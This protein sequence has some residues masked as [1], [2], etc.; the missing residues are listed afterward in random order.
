MK[1]AI[2][3]SLGQLLQKWGKNLANRAVTSKD[4]AQP[5]DNAAPKAKNPAGTPPAHWVALV[6][7]QA[8]WLLEGYDGS[9]NLDENA[10]PEQAKPVTN[11]ADPGASAPSNRPAKV[12]SVTDFNTVIVKSSGQANNESKAYS[13]SSAFDFAKDRSQSPS[14]P[15]SL[16]ATSFKRPPLM[17]PPVSPVSTPSTGGNRQSASI[18]GSENSGIAKQVINTVLSIPQ[19]FKSQKPLPEAAH[20]ADARL[21]VATTLGKAADEAPKSMPIKSRP[22]AQTQFV[23]QPT[24]NLAAHTTANHASPRSNQGIPQPVNSPLKAATRSQTVISNERIKPPRKESVPESFR[25]S[26][27]ASQSLRPDQTQAKSIEIKQLDMPV[28]WSANNWPALD[29][30]QQTTAANKQQRWPDLPE[31]HAATTAQAIVRPDYAAA[32][33]RQQARRL[34]LEHEQR[35]RTWNE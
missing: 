3:L 18:Q 7:D 2:L 12:E 9:S 26:N 30:E 19:R 6:K 8:P 13:Q 16:E 27:R 23:K 35:G 29:D 15:I 22:V 17:T 1:Q 14:K 11:G 10:Y 32:I 34:R 24:K 5:A 4:T 25:D 33:A 31:E 21:S 20:A 28:K